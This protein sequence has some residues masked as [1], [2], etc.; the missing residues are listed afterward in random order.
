MAYDAVRLF[1]VLLLV[2]GNFAVQQN[3]GRRPILAEQVS[4][5]AMNVHRG[6]EPL[7][8]DPKEL[9]LLWSAVGL[10]VAGRRFHGLTS[11]LFY[12]QFLRSN[13]LISFSV[14]I[15]P[16]SGG[17]F[18]L[19]IKTERLARGCRDRR[20][21]GR[22]EPKH[23]FATFENIQKGRRICRELVCHQGVASSVRGRMRYFKPTWE[24]VWVLPSVIGV[25][26]LVG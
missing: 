17:I 4:S 25:P 22:Q 11:S 2:M 8:V 9:G 12:V 1:E 6:L 21:N 15:R 23:R 19:A 16:A 5:E 10:M 7:R 13:E 24:L 20:L 26:M 3:Q 14:V 18:P